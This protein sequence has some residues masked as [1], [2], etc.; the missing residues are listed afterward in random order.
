MKKYYVYE[1]INPISGKIFYVGSAQGNENRAYDFN[2]RNSD[3]KR[4]VES[5]GGIDKIIIN[6]HKYFETASEA[7]RY[8]YKYIQRLH[9]INQALCSHEDTRGERNGMYKSGE[10]GIHP[11]GML[12]KT[13]SQEYKDVLSKRMFENNICQKGFWDKNGREHPKGMKDKSH[14]EQTKTQISE[15]LKQKHINCKSVT[16]ILP[17]KTQHNFERKQDAAKF[18]GMC[19]T[20]S[21]FIKLCK[22]G[23]PFEIKVKN[24]H[25]KKLEHL[26]GTIIIEHDTEVIL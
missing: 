8:E 1:H 25:T 14:S 3:W 23:K 20:G 13:H 22:T 12:G 24:Q 19:E 7:K 10:K 2:Q 18:L 9:D 6:I 21:S 11:K 5:F 15:T 26:I 16:V 17:D 4:E